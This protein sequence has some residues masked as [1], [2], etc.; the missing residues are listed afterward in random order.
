[1]LLFGNVTMFTI[2]RILHFANFGHHNDHK[3]YTYCDNNLTLF[4]SVDLSWSWGLGWVTS[5]VHLQGHIS[6]TV[7]KPHSL[8]NKNIHF[9]VH[10]EYY[11]PEMSITP[12]PKDIE[13]DTS[14]VEQV[15]PF[16]NKGTIPLECQKYHIH[17]KLKYH[18]FWKF[19]CTY[20]WD[21]KKSILMVHEW[22]Q[23]PITS[24]RQ[25]SWDI[26]KTSSMVNY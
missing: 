22:G 1:M 23:I 21:I 10:K 24:K 20:S 26:K 17:G 8:S 2:E 5:M 9:L 11:F 13:K 7:Q 19:E 15:G 12:P 3:I 25:Y 4:I 6:F 16:P 14:I 18:I